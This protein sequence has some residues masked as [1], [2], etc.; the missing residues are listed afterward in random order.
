M[1]FHFID[2]HIYDSN[3]SGA[4]YFYKRIDEFE[5]WAN[6][7][8]S[9]VQK[10]VGA[11]FQFGFGL[12]KIDKHMRLVF[13]VAAE[14]V[15]NN[16]PHAIHDREI[17]E[18]VVRREFQKGSIISFGLELVKDTR[19]HQIYPS[20]GYKVTMG[21][22]TALP[23]LNKHFSFI[24]SEIEGSCYNAL[25][26]RDFLVLGLHGKL[27]NIHELEHRKG[28]P[29]KD[30]FIMGGQSTVRGFVWGSV[31]PAWSTGEPLGA[32]NAMLFNAELVFPLAPDYGMR[33]HFFYD[34][35]AGWN[36]PKYT[37]AEID[38]IRR[39]SFDLRQS[40]GFGINL[41]RPMPAKID[42]GFKLDRRK[43]YGESSQ[44]FHLSMNYAW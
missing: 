41:M 14:D 6:V 11:N 40:I 10:V 23:L 25:I 7:S 35:G 30:L 20:E 3:V 38:H 36:T 4:Y 26:G 5:G 21:C 8:P 12:P 39:D 18:P 29:Y 43:E 44:E 32:R 27:G 15:N 31:G 28:I 13:D 9:P 22:H 19:N 42:W 17:F 34:A 1:E 24:K 16:N 37:K 33:G 2:P